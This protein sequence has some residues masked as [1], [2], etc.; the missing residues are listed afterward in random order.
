M[1]CDQVLGLTIK[2]YKAIKNKDKKWAILNCQSED[3]YER[4][5]A[6]II[7]KGLIDA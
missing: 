5:V 6:M 7:I 3:K 1:S 2:Q 4:F